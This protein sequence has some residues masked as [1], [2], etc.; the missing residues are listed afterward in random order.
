M[1][2]RRVHTPV[3]RSESFQSAVAQG[4]RHHARAPNTKYE[5]DDERSAAGKIPASSKKQHQFRSGPSTPSI[6]DTIL[7]L[8]GNKKAHDDA[9]MQHKEAPKM[10]K[11]EG[12]QQRSKMEA[13]LKRTLQSLA[14]AHNAL[15]IYPLRFFKRFQFSL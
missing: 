13:M 11:T 6:L 2:N 9:N 3:L 10:R 7:A 14:D 5:N 1:H 8:R 15:S 12:Q 4:R